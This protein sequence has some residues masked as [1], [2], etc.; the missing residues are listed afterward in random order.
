[1]NIYLYIYMYNYYFPFFLCRPNAFAVITPSRVFNLIADTSAEMHMW[2]GGTPVYYT[3]FMAVATLVCKI[4][5][6]IM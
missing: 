1:M 5:T 3:A 4:C 6:S 2:I